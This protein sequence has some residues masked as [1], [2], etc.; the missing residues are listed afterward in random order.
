MKFLSVHPSDWFILILLQTLNLYSGAL[1]L[2]RM[3]CLYF[4]ST[5]A[6]TWKGLEENK[7]SWINSDLIYNNNTPL[8]STQQLEC[9]LGCCFSG[10]LVELLFLELLFILI[11]LIYEFRF[12]TTK[13]L[14]FLYL[15]WIHTNFRFYWNECD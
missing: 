11:L 3:F 9:S 6:S 10:S 2:Q 15:H 12:Y 1:G 7:N 5:R 8:G 14:I 4:V 13:I